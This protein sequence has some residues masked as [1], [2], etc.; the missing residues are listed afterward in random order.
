MAL[1]KSII[2]ELRLEM[3]RPDHRSMAE[4]ARDLGTTKGVIAGA[5]SRAN[6][7]MGDSPQAKVERLEAQRGRIETMAAANTSAFA[8]AREIGCSE[9]AIQRFCDERGIHLH[10]R[11]RTPKPQQATVRSSMRGLFGKQKPLSDRDRAEMR[12][13]ADEAIAAG[14]ITRCPPGHAIGSKTFFRSEYA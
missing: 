2:E 1:S 8:I 3:K 13:L 5:F 10:V 6:I 14:R 12:R 4:V 11:I 7:R 9:R